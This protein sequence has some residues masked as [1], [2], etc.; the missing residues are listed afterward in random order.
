MQDGRNQEEGK[1]YKVLRDVRG[2]M[3]GLRKLNVVRVVPS[4]TALKRKVLTFFQAS[5]AKKKGGEHTEVPHG[6]AVGKY[7]CVTRSI[8]S[9][10][11]R[12]YVVHW[13]EI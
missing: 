5:E 13:N 4:L 3:V 12:R 1:T 8:T 2:E 10:A 7:V 9:W 11:M 6:F